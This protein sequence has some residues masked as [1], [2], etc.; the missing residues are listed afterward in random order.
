MTFG[1]L[2]IVNDKDDT[3]YAKL[4]YALA[5]SI[6]NTQREG[7]DKVALVINDKSRIENFISTWVFDE[8]IEWDGAE[9][10][11]GR[12]YMD[13]LTPWD[14]TICLD[15]DM[16]FLRDYSHWAEYFINN[17]ELYIANKAYTYRGDLVTN[18]YYRKCFTANDLPNLYSF[19]TFFVKDSP[20]AKDFFKVQREIIKNPELYA[21][22]FLHKYKPKIIGT[23]EAFA[24]AAKLLDITDEIA[25]P[26]EFPRTVHMKG[27]IQNWPYAADDCYDHIGF[28]F[29][30][31]G[32]L[33]LGNFEQNDIVHYVN[34][35]KV[36]LE[37]VN[38]LEEIAWKKNN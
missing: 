14:S 22:N 16:L 21:N 8:I 4:A 34:K 15:A 38:I 29:N 30:K 12:S 35:E 37:T 33:K 27:M 13:E 26:M 17:S 32:K 24:L 1:Y 31:K 18:D 11:D 9:H 20:L 25:Y 3:D 2:I 10:W 23:D 36:T 5:L 19:Y 28:Y 7:F 6:K